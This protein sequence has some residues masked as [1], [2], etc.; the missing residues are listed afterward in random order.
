MSGASGIVCNQGLDAGDCYPIA[1][2]VTH[3]GGAVLVTAQ[4]LVGCRY[5]LVSA[6]D[7]AR[8][9]D[10][11]AS[12]HPTILGSALPF[13]RAYLEAQRRHGDE[14]LFPHLQM[15]VSGGAP[16]PPDLHDEVR[17]VLGGRGVVSSYGLT[18]FP[19]ATAASPGDDDD[20]LAR[21]EGRLSPDVELRVVGTDG[22]EVPPG[23][24][25][26]LRFRGPQMMQGYVDSSLDAAAFD[27]LGYFR[28]GDL[29]CVEPSGHIR[30][31]GR[32][33][34]I[35]IRNAEN[36]SAQEIEDA[37][38]SHPAVADVAVIGVPDSRTGER[39]C[40]VVVPAH[41][42]EELTLASI[43]EHC[44]GLGL[45]TH[46]LPEQLVLVDSL[47][48]NSMGKVLKQQLRQHLAGG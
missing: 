26:E 4:L 22:A 25:G 10:L 45:A 9:P 43:G 30:I 17:R 12:H 48:R 19:I 6:F 23:E 20:M 32:L 13:I 29:G 35:I 40:A 47:P 31:T 39:A 11:M 46:K 16:K 33:K 36:I 7:P 15:C 21:T 3:I 34:D 28:S 37:V 14:P 41:P 42:G 18:E 38:A 24:E 44:R 8:T 27:E 1:F 5:L 2:P